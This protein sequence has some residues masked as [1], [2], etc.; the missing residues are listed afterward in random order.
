MQKSSGHRLVFP[1]LFFILP[2]VYFAL[3]GWRGFS[4]TDQGFI[5]GIAWRLQLGQTPFQDFIYVRPM[6]SPWIH[7]GLQ[8]ILPEKFQILGSRFFFYLFMW[9]SVFL[10]VGALKRFFEVEKWGISGWLLGCVGF[11]LSVHNF[12]PMPWHT[13][14]GLLLS[15]LGIFLLTRK[16]NIIWG[17][18]GFLSL[19]GAA[20]CKQSFYPAPLIGVFLLIV[21]YPRKKMWM[22]LAGGFTVL[23]GVLFLLFLPEGAGRLFMEQSKGTGQLKDLLQA[24]LGTYVKPWL[25]L[26]LPALLGVAILQKLAQKEKLPQK[27][28]HFINSGNLGWLFWGGAIALIG[29]T[30]VKA[31]LTASHLPPQWGYPQVLFGFALVPCIIGLIRKEKKYA[32]LLAMLAISWCTG[33]SWGY[34]WPVLGFLP[35]LGG[36]LA[37]SKEILSFQPPRWLFPAALG[38]L[39]LFNANLYRF[40]YHDAGPHAHHLGDLFPKATGIFVGATNFQKHQELMSLISRYG[41]S[42]AV[43]PAMPLAHFLNGSEPLLPVDWAHNAEA[44]FEKNSSWLIDR[45][46]HGPNVVFIEKDKLHEAETSGKYG[47]ALTAYVLE[48]WNEIENEEYFYVYKP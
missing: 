29:G 40:P 43:L 13:V 27:I 2:L 11:V 7:Y 16:P 15:S 14:D 31:L 24:G 33:V 22:S 8:L 38:I 41:D 28:Q 45:L 48:N 23:A 46:N 18:L 35:I 4:D 12:P 42:F 9:G 6:L 17:I 47:S 19:V 39:F 36:M 25:V 3:F 44:N 32:V 34:A 21:C 30:S 1:V 10:G 37:Y 20:F 26:T 5:Q